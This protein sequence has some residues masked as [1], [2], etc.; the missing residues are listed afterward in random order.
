M[1]CNAV[2]LSRAHAVCCVVQLSF[3]VSP[4]TVLK[5]NKMIV[6]VF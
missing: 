6:P 4:S 3:P 2:P 5:I 1:Q